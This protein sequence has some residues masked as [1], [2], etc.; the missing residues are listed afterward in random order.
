MAHNSQLGHLDFAIFCTLTSG[1][2]AAGN[3]I[4]YLNSSTAPLMLPKPGVECSNG[5]NI[6]C[7]ANVCVYYSLG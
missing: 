5:L 1:T 6:V 2:G 7:D 3:Q 4:A